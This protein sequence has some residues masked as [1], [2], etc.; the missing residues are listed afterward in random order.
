MVA[1]SRTATLPVAAAVIV[2]TVSYVYLSDTLHN[3]RTGESL[4]ELENWM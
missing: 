2:K 4:E 3:W 1:K